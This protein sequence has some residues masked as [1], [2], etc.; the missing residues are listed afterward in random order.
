MTQAMTQIDTTRDAYEYLSGQWHSKPRH[1]YSETE[2][3]AMP[4]QS[5]IRL[6]RMHEAK[7]QTQ[8]KE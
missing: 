3:N 5:L 6:A 8:E 2:L 7:N 4:D 1:P